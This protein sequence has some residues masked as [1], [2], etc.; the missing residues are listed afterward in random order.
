MK[1]IAG[2]V[3]MTSQLYEQLAAAERAYNELEW[4]ARHW[5]EASPEQRERWQAFSD[6]V[7]R[8]EDY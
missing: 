8:M 4:I 2:R 6:A 5:D 7:D 3:T 1:Y